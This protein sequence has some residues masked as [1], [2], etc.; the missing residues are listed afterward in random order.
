MAAVNRCRTEPIDPRDPSRSP[1]GWQNDGEGCRRPHQKDAEPAG[2]FVILWGGESGRA[3]RRDGWGCLRVGVMR[4]AAAS[5]GMDSPGW[6]AV[7]VVMGER[8]DG[9]EGDEEETKDHEDGG[10]PASERNLLVSVHVQM[11]CK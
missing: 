3:A 8:R 4:V 2:G 6:I 9:G 7:L 5:M 1:D 11:R 10:E